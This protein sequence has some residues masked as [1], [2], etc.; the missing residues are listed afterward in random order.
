MQPSIDGDV[1]I[2]AFSPRSGSTSRSD[3]VPTSRKDARSLFSNSSERLQ[4]IR[5]IAEV[6]ELDAHPVHDPKVHAAEFA[7]FVPV[8]AVVKDAAGLECP[9][10]AAG[11]HDGDFACVVL[12]SR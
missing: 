12:R 6:L 1:S 7:A 10:Q 9:P 5:C 4:S 3:N 11:E 8:I 2:A